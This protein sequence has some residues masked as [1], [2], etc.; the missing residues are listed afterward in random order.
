MSKT[1]NQQIIIILGPPGAGKGTQSDLLQEKFELGYIGTGELLRARKEIPDYTGK[2]LIEIMDAGKILPTPVVLKMWMDR[3]EE[4]KG[5]SVFKGFILDGSPR[6]VLEAEMIEQALGW[7]DWETNKRVIFINLSEQ[8][9]ID[10]L[11]KRRTCKKCGRIIPY[12]DEC[13]GELFVRADDE[14]ADIKERLRWYK[15]DVLPVVDYYRQ[16]GILIE[17]DGDQPI[18]KVYNDILDKLK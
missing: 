18:E 10:R 16:K 3:F 13:G 8:D 6:T 4:L 2:K 12:I 17:I 7:Y 9:S 5:E 15:E 11:T 1:D 14:P